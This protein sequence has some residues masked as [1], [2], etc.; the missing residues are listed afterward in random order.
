MQIQNFIGGYMNR[1]TIVLLG[2]IAII[3]SIVFGVLA[4]NIEDLSA[5]QKGS[6]N[7]IDSKIV[8]VS[9]RD[10]NDEIY[11]INPDELV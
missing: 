4:F 9:K 1:N 10:G 5:T 8:F 6:K 2:R 3:F 11:I 7:S